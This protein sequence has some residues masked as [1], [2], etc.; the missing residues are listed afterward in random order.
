MHRGPVAKEDGALRRAVVAGVTFVIM[1]NACAG[2]MT[3]DEYVEDL[4][5]LVAIGLSEFEAASATYNQI[6]QPT[7][8]DEVAFLEQEVAIRQ[9]FLEGFEALDPPGSITEVHRLLGDAFMRLTAAAEG[10]A[11]AAG[12]SNSI[13]DAEETPEFA[14]YLAANDDGARVCLD[15]QAR[16]DDLATTGEAVADEPWLSGLGLAVRAAIGCGE[17]DAD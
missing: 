13:E 8:A 3:A 2:S 14:E 11:A 15:V 5:A 1:L 16:L 9:E 17:I 4:N 12:T 6:A 7:L 10:L